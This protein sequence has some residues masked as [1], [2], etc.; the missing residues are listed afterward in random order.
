M[1]PLPENNTDRFWL[2]YTDGQ[3]DHELLVRFNGGAG[4]VPNVMSSVDQFFTAL[5]PI[6]YLLTVNGARWSAQGSV[7]S[8]PLIWDGAATY[9][10][11]AM[12]ATL[13]PR[14][15]CYLG[16]DAQG[17]RVRWFVFG[18]EA[19]PPTAF[20]IGA[21]GVTEFADAYAVISAGNADGVWLTIAGLDPVLYGY[22]D[23]NYNS[24]Y[25]EKAR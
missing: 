11:F 12:P 9:G 21:G 18:W 25:E 5:S 23:I 22:V 15:L 16:R 24:Y 1:A 4:N 13:A 17:R 8:Q 10:Q 20:R 14:Q 19:A 6:L 3:N 2:A 7:I